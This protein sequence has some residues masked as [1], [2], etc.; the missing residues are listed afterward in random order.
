MYYFMY[1]I[2]FKVALSGIGIIR[3]FNLIYYNIIVFYACT[4]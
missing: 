1:Y 3:V 2:T 4:F